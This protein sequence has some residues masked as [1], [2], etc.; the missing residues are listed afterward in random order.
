[1]AQP[2]VPL[3]AL[4]R[5]IIVVG[6]SAGGVEAIA[7][8]ARNLPADFAGTVFVVLH[9]PEGSTSALPEIIS[10]VGLLPAAA[11]HDG[12]RFEPGTILVAPPDHHLLV[13]PGQR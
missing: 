12:V 4:E 13:E 10:H 9:L 1:M 8:V 7:T 11:A 5:D 2:A 6:A 3:Q